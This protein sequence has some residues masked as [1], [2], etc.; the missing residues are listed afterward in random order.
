MG[1]EG[2]KYSLFF[3]CIPSLEQEGA[4]KAVDYFNANNIPYKKCG[5]L[6]VAVDQSELGR[7]ENLFTNSLK[8]EVPDVRM[9]E[10]LD[11]IQSIESNCQGLAAIHSPSTSIVDWGDVTRSYAQ[12]FESLGGE[13]YLGFEV[14]SIKKNGYYE[15]AV[16]KFLSFLNVNIGT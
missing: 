12:K 9:C 16:S 8:N 3:V 7:L 1:T 13:I 5:K 11:E 2:S 10:N 14:S 6:V 15:K 4:R